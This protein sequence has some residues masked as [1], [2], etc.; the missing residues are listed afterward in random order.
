MA[1]GGNKVFQLSRNG[2]FIMGEGGVMRMCVAEVRQ[3][4]WLGVI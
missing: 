1:F 4:L 2:E 3:F